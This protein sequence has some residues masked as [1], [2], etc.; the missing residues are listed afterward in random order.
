MILNTEN[1]GVLFSAKADSERMYLVYE[2]PR[3]G[4]VHRSYL[5][6]QV[7]YTSINDFSGPIEAVDMYDIMIMCR[8]NPID[9]VKSNKFLWIAGSSL[10]D[11][12]ITYDDICSRCRRLW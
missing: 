7:F 1:K 3:G 5:Q 11:R 2:Y 6:Q 10:P 4:R 8:N 12:V 9:R